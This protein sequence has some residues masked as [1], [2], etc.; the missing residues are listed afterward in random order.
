M[1]FALLLNSVS[2]LIATGNIF[3]MIKIFSEVTPVADAPRAW[4]LMAFGLA[5]I[6]IHLSLNMFIWVNPVL[7][8]SSMHHLSALTGIAGFGGLFFGAR[9][10]HRVISV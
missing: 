6:V 5:M 2:L 10:V 1:E 9:E 7:R 4:S 3:L 8:S